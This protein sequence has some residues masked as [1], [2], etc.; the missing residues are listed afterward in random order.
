M[1]R[2]RRAKRAK[3][4]DWLLRIECWRHIS[5]LLSFEHDAEVEKAESHGRRVARNVRGKVKKEKGKRGRENGILHRHQ[6]PFPK[7][8]WFRGSVGFLPTKPKPSRLPLDLLTSYRDF[9][10]FEAVIIVDRLRGWFQAAGRTRCSTGV[11]GAKPVVE[12]SAQ[13]WILHPRA[14]GREMVR[15][16]PLKVP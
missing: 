12:V 5:P 1:A 2:R 8:T 3:R 13:W 15:V 14:L 6:G 10:S 4:L 7:G 11:A 16:Q 9:N